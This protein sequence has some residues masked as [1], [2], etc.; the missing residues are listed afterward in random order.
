MIRKH[1]RKENHNYKYKHGHLIG[2]GIYF[3]IAR[4]WARNFIEKKIPAKQRKKF[5]NFSEKRGSLAIFI[6]RVNPI[7]SSDIF[8]YIAEEIT[9]PSAS[10]VTQEN[11]P[12]SQ[13]MNTAPDN[14][15][16]NDKL[17]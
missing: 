2:D 14:N 10:S 16:T 11:M 3:Q 17:N 1:T 4:S 12:E 5:D 13:E 7:T 8:S 9:E 15:Y 6:L